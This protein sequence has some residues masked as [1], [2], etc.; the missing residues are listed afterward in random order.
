VPRE[1]EHIGSTA[2]SGLKAKPILDIAIW[3]EDDYRIENCIPLIEAS[4][5]LYRG[6]SED[7]GH[8]LVRE[9]ENQVRTHH[10]HIVHL[11]DAPWERWLTF[12]THLR[13]SARAR[14]TYAAEKEALWQSAIR[15]TGTHTRRRRTR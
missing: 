11:N 5:Y 1:I 6:A 9:I 7:A 12:R 3:V 2:V 15:W 13:K 4:G 14:L 10:V 8:V